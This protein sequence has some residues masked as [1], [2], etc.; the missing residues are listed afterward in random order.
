M[1]ACEHARHACCISSVSLGLLRASMCSARAQL[2]AS[3]S[4]LIGVAI[5]INM[6]F[7]LCT[8]QAVDRCLPLLTLPFSHHEECCQNVS[9]SQIRVPEQLHVCKAMVKDS[10]DA[11]MER[12]CMLP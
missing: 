7:I 2:I 3:D 11:R 8:Q 1:C 5:L 4:L 6:S 12:C 9:G 10:A